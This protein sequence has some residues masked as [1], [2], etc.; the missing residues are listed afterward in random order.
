[1]SANRLA[2]ALCLA[3]LAFLSILGG[4]RSSDEDGAPGENAGTVSFPCTC[5]T[6]EA[7]LEGCLHAACVSGEGN[8]DN[9]DCVCG[10]LSFESRSGE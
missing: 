6:P 8:P 4:C 3:T 9:P 1:M 2:T 5:G 10:P 7:A